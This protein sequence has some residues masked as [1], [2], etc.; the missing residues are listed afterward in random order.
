MNINFEAAIAT[1]KTAVGLDTQV[2]EETLGKTRGEATMSDE[3]MKLTIVMLMMIVKRQD[4]MIQV[5]AGE[6]VDLQAEPTKKFWQFW[7]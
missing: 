4:Q 3:D 5:L 7:K 1:Y 6:I 2:L